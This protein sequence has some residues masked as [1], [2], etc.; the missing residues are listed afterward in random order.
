MTVFQ[1]VLKGFIKQIL[2]SLIDKDKAESTNLHHSNFG[3][4]RLQL[5]L[6]HRV[7]YGFIWLALS[8]FL[9]LSLSLSLDGTSRRY[10]TT[11]F[12]SR[13]RIIK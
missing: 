11:I 1:N 9:S 8:L 3:S 5:V 10:S 2:E 6:F 4:S 12:I 7:V 13:I